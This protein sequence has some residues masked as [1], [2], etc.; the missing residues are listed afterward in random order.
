MSS[1]SD[2]AAT[3]RYLSYISGIALLEAALFGFACGTP[4]SVVA[5]DVPAFA[6][7]MINHMQ[8]M[9]QFK[10]EDPDF[11]HGQVRLRAAHL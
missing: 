9:E 3:A 1:H 7:G 2:S 6:P 10:D 11:P 5:Q 8:Q 4:Q